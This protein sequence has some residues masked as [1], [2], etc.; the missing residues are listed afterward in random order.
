VCESSVA[1]RRRYIHGNLFHVLY[2]GCPRLQYLNRYRFP[3]QLDSTGARISCEEWKSLIR[4]T[5][6]KKAKTC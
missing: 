2:A 5:I 4:R 3:S 6:L 1:V